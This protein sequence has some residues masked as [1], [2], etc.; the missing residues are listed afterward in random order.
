MAT[1]YPNPTTPIGLRPQDALV[2]LL[3]AITEVVRAV[4]GAQGTHFFGPEG[5]A[6]VDWSHGRVATDY[7]VPPAPPGMSRLDGGTWDGEHATGSD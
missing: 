6:Q 7:E 3:Q 5:R 4:Y 1:Q 2:N